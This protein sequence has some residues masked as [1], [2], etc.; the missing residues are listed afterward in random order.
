M[1]ILFFYVLV[2]MWVGREGNSMG[3]V[4]H[5]NQRASFDIYHRQPLSFL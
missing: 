4:S 2:L 5:G 3:I 1:K